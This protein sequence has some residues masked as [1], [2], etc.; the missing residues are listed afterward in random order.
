MSAELRSRHNNNTTCSLF[1]Q[2]IFETRAG[3]FNFKKLLDFTSLFKEP[4]RLGMQIARNTFFALDFSVCKN[5]RFIPFSQGQV[6]TPQNRTIGVN[7]RKN[8]ILP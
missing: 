3:P 4:V 1:C 5:T 2:V 6:S 8:R 7:L